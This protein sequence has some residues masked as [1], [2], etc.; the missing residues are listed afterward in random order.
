MFICS[1]LIHSS[2]IA[3]YNILG[4]LGLYPK[5]VEG[6]SEEQSISG[7]LHNPEFTNSQVRSLQTGAVFAKDIHRGRTIGA[8]APAKS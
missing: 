5:K 2:S 6:Q 8:I 7:H 4:W 1:Q 3:T